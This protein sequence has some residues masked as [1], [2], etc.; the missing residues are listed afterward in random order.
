MAEKAPKASMANSRAAPPST[1][2]GPDSLPDRIPLKNRP[3][4]KTH[5]AAPATATTPPIKMSKILLSRLSRFA[6]G[7][8]ITLK[9]TS[10]TPCGRQL[11]A[12]PERNHL[13]L[14]VAE[15]T[16][17]GLAGAVPGED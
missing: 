3:T 12:L 5:A 17:E 2:R 16:P 7:D 1:D 14:R 4:S 11:E 8:P 15:V 6:G 13:V 10:E 9:V